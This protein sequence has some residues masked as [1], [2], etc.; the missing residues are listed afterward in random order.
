[1]WNLKQT[2]RTQTKLIQ[3]EIRFVVMGVGHGVE[4][5]D[6]GGQKVQTFSC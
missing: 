1:M 6:E 5:L 2:N 3:K 4:E